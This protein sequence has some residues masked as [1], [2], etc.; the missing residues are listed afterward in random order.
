MSAVGTG[1]APAHLSCQC[2]SVPGTLVGGGQGS[3]EHAAQLHDPV[4]GR[5]FTQSPSPASFMLWDGGI[6]GGLL[7]EALRDLEVSSLEAV[8]WHARSRPAIL[9]EV[10]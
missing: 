2:S 3:P 7:T 5:P 10:N 8:F 4:Q 1:S 6:T 9:C